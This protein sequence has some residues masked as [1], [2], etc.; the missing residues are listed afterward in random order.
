MLSAATAV[1]SRAA[2]RLVVVARGSAEVFLFAAL[3]LSYLALFVYVLG[4]GYDAFDFH[5]FW[6]SGRDV[7]NGH[8]PYSASLPAVAHMDTFRPFVYPA[9]AALAMIP[10][11]A[12]PYGVAN[13]LWFVVGLA[14]VVGALRL[15]GVRD[16]RCYG[17]LLAWPA[18]WSSLVNGAISALLVLGCAALWRYRDRAYVAGTI[19]AALVVFK[20]YLWPLGV[21]LLVTRRWRAGATSVAV[22]AAATFGAWAAIGFAGFRGYPHVLGRLTE[23]VGPNSY[24]PY[25][26]FRALGAGPTAAQL[27]MFACGVVVLAAALVVA[28]RGERSGF[29]LAIAASLSLTPIVWPH[30]LALAAVAVALAWP[31]LSP[32]WIVPMALWFV[33]PSWSNGHPL[34]IG[35]AIAAFGA[36]FACS[37][38]RAR[39]A[40]AA[41]RRAPPI[42]RFAVK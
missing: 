12:L 42:V 22:A 37:A 34:V 24:S 40:P 35:G 2:M 17:A 15:L 39:T 25:A 33:L 9:P 6:H 23:L 32:A 5:T 29:V 31:N 4:T 20:L 38:F 16:W 18:V 7:L 21:W 28:R 14:A 11:S 26:L 41:A 8:S 1:Q 30:Y 10:F 3:P 36:L 19:V 27:M 13:A